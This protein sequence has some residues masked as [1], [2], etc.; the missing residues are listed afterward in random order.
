MSE[1]ISISIFDRIFKEVFN[2]RIERI[3]ISTYEDKIKELEDINK[4]LAKEL[5]K[6]RFKSSYDNLTGVLTRVEFEKRLDHSFSLFKRFSNRHFSLVFIDLNDFKEVNDTYGHEA[7]DNILMGFAQFLK[8]YLRESDLIGR[9]S[10]GGDEFLL[11]LEESN[12]KS[13]VKA[14]RKIESALRECK[15]STGE[16]DISVSFCRGIVS[17]SEKKKVH[18]TKGLMKEAD[19]RMYKQKEKRK[20]LNA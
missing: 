15:I 5:A 4:E 14:I 11:L 18:D 8:T 10:G 9:L 1:K 13:G 19:M 2:D 16:K 3:H 12:L 20:R 17:T 7:G 6:E